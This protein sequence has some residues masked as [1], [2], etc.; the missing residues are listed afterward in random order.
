MKPQEIRELPAEEAKARLDDLLDELA[1][2]NIQKST[3]Q[4]ANPSR[5]RLVKKDIARIK[6]IL[7][8]YQLGISAPKTTKK[9]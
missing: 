5:I 3:H 9:E 1:N 2:L 7:N 6:G 4:L 8:E